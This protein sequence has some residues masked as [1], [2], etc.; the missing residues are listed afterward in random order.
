MMQA[1]HSFVGK[2]EQQVMIKS[3]SEA[4]YMDMVGGFHG[5]VLGDF[6]RLKEHLITCWNF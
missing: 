2:Q 4:D 6:T 5:L 1:C 3:F